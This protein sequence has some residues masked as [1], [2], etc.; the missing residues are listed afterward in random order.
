MAVETRCFDP[1]RYLD[2]RDARAAYMTEARETSDPDFIADALRVIAR[3][4]VMSSVAPDTSWR[5]IC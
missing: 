2:S 1:A 5:S 3:A 4:R